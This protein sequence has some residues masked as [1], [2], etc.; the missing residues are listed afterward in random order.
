MKIKTIGVFA[1]I[2][3]S[4]SEAALWAHPV[5]RPQLQRAQVDRRVAHQMVRINAGVKTGAL[6][7]P[8]ARVLRKELRVVRRDIRHDRRAN[9]GYLTRAQK[10][11]LNHRLNHNSR[12]IY[13]WKRS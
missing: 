2:L 9:G 13:A 12:R 5:C 8:E 4:A 7:R 3:F 6:T 1:L 10:R 11:G